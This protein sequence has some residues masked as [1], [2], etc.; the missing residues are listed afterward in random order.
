VTCA[1]ILFFG[2]CTQEQADPT[3]QRLRQ[4]TKR[5]ATIAYL[6]SSRDICDSVY[7]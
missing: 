6:I 5:Q 1:V 4:N 7:K 3:C 2:A